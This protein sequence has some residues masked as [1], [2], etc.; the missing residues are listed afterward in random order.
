MCEGVGRRRGSAGAVS[1]CAV[2]VSRGLAF[3]VHERAISSTRRDASIPQTHTYHHDARKNF[4]TPSTTPL[5]SSSPSLHLA[6]Y[7]HLPHIAISPP[8]HLASPSLAISPRHLSPPSS[9]VPRPIS[10]HLP[11]SILPLLSSPLH[12]S[13]LPWYSP[14]PSPMSS[15]TC[16][17]PHGP[18]VR[19]LAAATGAHARGVLRPSCRG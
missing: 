16:S 18:P 9:L 11:R 8:R 6:S 12:I 2:C 13:P 4:A 17:G 14:S 10:R 19:S 5:A 15:Q 3:F 7:R 1:V